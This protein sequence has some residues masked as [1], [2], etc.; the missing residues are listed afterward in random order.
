[1]AGPAA[2]KEGRSVGVS[3]G[4]H[5]LSPC[6]SPPGRGMEIVLAPPQRGR[7]AVDFGRPAA[8]EPGGLAAALR[9]D[10]VFGFPPAVPSGLGISLPWLRLT[11]LA[12]CSGGMLEGQPGPAIRPAAAP[13]PMTVPNS[14]TCCRP[15]GMLM[16]PSHSEHPRKCAPLLGAPV[17][18]EGWQAL[19][20]PLEHLSTTVYLELEGPQCVV[21]TAVSPAW[22]KRGQPSKEAGEG[23]DLLEGESEPGLRVRSEHSVS[24]VRASRATCKGQGGT[25][26]GFSTARSESFSPG[27]K[28]GWAAEPAASGPATNGRKRLGPAWPPS[29]AKHLP[30]SGP[31]QCLSTPCPALA[32]SAHRG[33]GTR[34]GEAAE[35]GEPQAGHTAVQG[36]NWKVERQTPN[37][38]P[39]HINARLPMSLR[40][41]LS[42]RALGCG[43]GSMTLLDTAL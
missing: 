36:Q 18:V 34:L 11:V 12:A 1:M 16:E 32:G 40:Y 8:L 41:R 35:A 31:V 42:Q 30:D 38:H 22:K 7:L 39:L 20:N 21:S 28:R 4:V 33:P 9:P 26:T 17:A 25:D 19:T 10:N 43:R 6:P 2:Q 29:T 24:D 15:L 5:E 27:A 13:P 37:P 3:Q 14:P 23:E